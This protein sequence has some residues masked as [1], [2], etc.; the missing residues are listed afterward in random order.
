VDD[1]KRIQANN[2]LLDAEVL[3][4]YILDAFDN[5]RKPGAPAALAADPRVAEAVWR[6]LTSGW[7]G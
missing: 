1:F 3:T 6:A 2:Q 5:A 7:K 4:P